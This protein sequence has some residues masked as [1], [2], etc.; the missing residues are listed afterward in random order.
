MERHPVP[1]AIEDDRSEAEWFDRMPRGEHSATMALNRVEG[2][3]E[4]AIR[5]QVEQRPAF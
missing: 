2:L 1:F 4:T 3:I 5:I